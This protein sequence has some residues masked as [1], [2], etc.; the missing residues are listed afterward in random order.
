MTESKQALKKK[1]YF[2]DENKK[3][4]S[5]VKAFIEYVNFSEA[6]EQMESTFF[7]KNSSK[8]YSAT[9]DSF[10]GYQTKGIGMKA[11]KRKIPKSNNLSLLFTHVNKLLYYCRNLFQ[12]K[13]QHRSFTELMVFLCSLE[14]RPE[15]RVSGIDVLLTFMD[16][17]NVKC[18]LKQFNALESS[19]CFD[20]F[21][22][23]F[24]NEKI[25]LKVPPN[26]LEIEEINNKEKVPDSKEERRMMFQKMLTFILEKSTEKEFWFKTIKNYFLTTLYPIVSEKLGLLDGKTK[27]G[28]RN[29]C[30]RELQEDII[31]FIIKWLGNDEI[32][33]IIYNDP[34][35]MDLILEIFR[36]ALLLPSS[37][38][39]SVTMVL[40]Q[41][42]F[43][44]NN[45]KKSP[46]IRNNIQYYVQS[47]V[48]YLIQSIL[49]KHE[50]QQ[51]EILV[52]RNKRILQ[53]IHTITNESTSTFTKKTWNIILENLIIVTQMFLQDEFLNDHNSL[54]FQLSGD[55]SNCLFNVFINS[56]TTSRY[57]WNLLEQTIKKNKEWPTVCIQWKRSL[58]ILTLQLH[59]FLF[60]TDVKVTKE[61][62]E[63]ELLKL[64]QEHLILE[65]DKVRRNRYTKK[66]ENDIV[67]IPPKSTLELNLKYQP[68]K[69][70]L[71]WNNYSAIFFWREFFHLYHNP[72]LICEPFVHGLCIS[73]YIETYNIIT[74]LEKQYP[75]DVKY[76]KLPILKLFSPIFILGCESNYHYNS[77]KSISYGALC[78][79]FC[80]PQE[81]IN[82]RYLANFYLIIIKGLLLKNH[83]ITTNILR[84][85]SHIFGYCLPGSTILIG[86]YLRAIE[87]YLNPNYKYDLK[88]DTI[89]HAITLLS[90]IIC[91]EDHFG[92]ISIY[93]GEKIVKLKVNELDEFI[94]I[95]ALLEK[96]TN[97][98][99]Q[100]AK[101]LVKLQFENN[102]E[103]FEEIRDL[104][105]DREI[106]IIQEWNKESLLEKIEEYMIKKQTIRELIAKILT[107]FIL[108][109]SLQIDPIIF[110]ID[111]KNSRAKKRRR[112]SISVSMESFSQSDNKGENNISDNNSGLNINN[113]NTRTSNKNLTG[114]SLSEESIK[115]SIFT[116][117]SIVIS[118]LYSI[119]PRVTI[120]QNILDS[121]VPHL[122]NLSD[123]LSNSANFSLR[124]LASLSSYLIE[125]DPEIV[126]NL[127]IK[128]CQVINQK[129]ESLKTT[130][131]E[132]EKGERERDR[133]N[134][135][136]V[137]S[138][139]SAPSYINHILYTILVFLMNNKNM[140]IKE[141][142]NSTLF[143][144]L[145]KA[146]A[147]QR[148]RQILL[149]K[150][151]TNLKNNQSPRRDSKEEIKNKKKKR[152]G[153]KKKKHKK[154]RKNSSSMEQEWSGSIEQSIV[155]TGAKR[156]TINESEKNENFKKIRTQIVTSEIVLIALL[157][158]WNN[159]PFNA[160]PEFI[161]SQVSDLDD[162]PEKL[163]QQKI[164]E[165][166]E[167]IKHAQQKE[168]LRN[169][170][171]VNLNEK[172]IKKDNEDE[173]NAIDYLEYSQLF[174]F[175]DS[176][177]Q[178]HELPITKNERWVR[179]ILRDP[180]GKY[181]WDAKDLS[182]DPNYQKI[183]RI[184]KFEI[185]IVPK[186]FIRN[187]LFNYNKI[188]DSQ[189]KLDLSNEMNFNRQFGLLPSDENLKNSNLHNLDVDVF[190]ELLKYIEE[191]K[192]KDG[193]DEDED[194]DENENE[195]ENEN[196]NENENE[197]KEIEI[198]KEK[199]KEKEIGKEKE[200][201]IEKE[202]ES[203]KEKEIENEKEK[204]K[205]KG[206][207]KK[208]FKDF[209]EKLG[210]L[211]MTT[212]PDKKSKRMTVKFN[213][214]RTSSKKKE[215]S[216]SF[217]QPNNIPSTFNQRIQIERK[218]LTGEKKKNLLNLIQQ[219][220]KH[221]T[222]HLKSDLMKKEIIDQ[223]EEMKKLISTDEEFK[224]MINESQLKVKP[225][226]QLPKE[227]P[228]PLH[229]FHYC[230]LLLSHF[231]LVSLENLKNLIPLQRNQRVERSLKE[232]DKRLSRETQKIGV[233]YVGKNQRSKLQILK[234]EK[235]SASFEEFV[236]GLGWEVQLK[237]HLGYRG[238]LDNY[239]FENGRTAP[240]Y[241]DF[242]SEVIFHVSTW[243]PNSNKDENQ[244]HK[245]K[246]FSN[247]FVNIIWCEDSKE[248]D[249]KII[250]SK[251]NYVHI[252]IYPLPNGL[253]RF[254]INSKPEIPLF[255]LLIDGM[256]VTKQVLPFLV[257]Q[258]A[259]MA[260][261]F[262]NRARMRD[263]RHPYSYRLS[264]I[265]ETIERYKMDIGFEEYFKQII[266]GNSENEQNIQ[267][268]QNILNKLK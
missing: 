10:Y 24:P 153:L 19:V 6:D 30:H 195:N 263:V 58:L 75:M 261:R 244:L 237:S 35:N 230:R 78:N 5:R 80:T 217:N 11:K 158:L 91:F 168:K 89:I 187:D 182:K 149:A 71:S 26:H 99:E 163:I 209:T 226:F 241:S 114:D 128:L 47:I 127:I 260:T 220:R 166:R 264:L 103:N 14:N 143:L 177:I 186:K 202:N 142:I 155:T 154:H 228:L 102:E 249:T 8:L 94:K 46:T 152:L 191:N 32:C 171:S 234:N 206:I 233:I 179:L 85:S 183:N 63:V 136:K 138:V 25:I 108:S 27:T 53:L 161:S 223:D 169:K 56:K 212:T 192:K 265:N 132:K 121:I 196:K 52:K 213:I 199:E 215:K 4:L 188:F 224:E 204:G 13:W 101:K 210:I 165:T 258:T 49:I 57:H 242:D 189:S 172:E 50:T 229:F 197:N 88:P 69:S 39:K 235:G 111:P 201:E 82:Q 51:A 139:I 3:A 64:K 126:S 74:F 156:Y 254:Q 205:G 160:G 96:E 225:N 131:R 97:E 140:I 98:R 22:K 243:M 104:E 62:E 167:K 66:I 76:V 185:P 118:E 17:L 81:P 200:R 137:Q 150:S 145:I 34:Q 174:A 180:T 240:Y 84:F 148:E 231:G 12:K 112:S 7:M 253:F 105:L 86:T 90:S 37:Y 157:N 130:I 181:V 93:E 68:P 146:I 43:W 59:S 15:C 106:S 61:E 23:D 255:G 144:T 42:T 216:N 173:I 207:V 31:Q 100:C 219:S 151:Q 73:G 55:L 36:Q 67:L 141:K 125:L 54:Q 133:D 122:C 2:L 268:F 266:I 236:T 211:P 33:G 178:V 110:K 113:M 129:I 246:H 193:Q 238:G 159:Y 16:T 251:N 95:Q 45:L 9:I 123:N 135:S 41:F 38:E 115:L 79:I 120:I 162:L 117:I 83:E 214:L 164:I 190:N 18:D 147:F 247:D 21:L 134:E 116:L 87:N 257:R 29:S 222:E 250:I 107:T 239:T 208:N 184:S 48:K 44:F 252:I 124:T 20:S 203:E 248:Y 259:T 245:K 262:S 221:Q 1:E 119:N 65:S 109:Q 40:D 267:L 70:F 198:E 194:E 77:G 92:G 175:E 176:I 218:I 256:I 72:N 60:Q 227:C 170:D 232:L 28:F